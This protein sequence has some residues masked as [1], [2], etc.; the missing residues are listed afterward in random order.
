M[1]SSPGQTW[2]LT[3]RWVFPVD[4]PPLEHGRVTIVGERIV[5]VE[6]HHGEPADV[7]L[8]EVALLPGL[9]NAHTHLDLSGLRGLAPPSPDFTAWLR[10]VIAHRRSRSPEQVQDDIRAGLAECLR[11]GTTLVGD[12]AGSEGCRRAVADAPVRAVVFHERQ[13]L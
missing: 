3:A 5:A 6:P 8:G 1:D 13:G 10:Q 4:R 11:H 2:S 7:D 9:V 12:I